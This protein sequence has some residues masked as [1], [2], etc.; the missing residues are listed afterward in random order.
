MG[1]SGVGPAGTSSGSQRTKHPTR[2]LNREL[3]ATPTGEQDLRVLTDIV[4]RY[5]L[6]VPASIVRKV[7]VVYPLTQRVSGRKQRRGDTLPNHVVL[8]GKSARS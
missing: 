8:S 3:L 4:A 6:W 7:R 1:E 5:S 2:V